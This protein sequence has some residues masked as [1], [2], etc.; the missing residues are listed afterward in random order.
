M[1]KAEHNKAAEP[2]TSHHLF[3]DAH[4]KTTKLRAALATSELLTI[5]LDVPMTVVQVFGAVP[6]LMSFRDI[7]VKALP[8]SDI[9][10]FDMLN[11]FAQALNDGGGR[12]PMIRNCV[13]VLKYPLADRKST[14]LNSSH[15][16]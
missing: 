10:Q 16:P 13:S 15:R 12:G 3:H 5:N 14:R 6:R 7:I 1:T 2:E 8:E 11:T 9:H 4:D